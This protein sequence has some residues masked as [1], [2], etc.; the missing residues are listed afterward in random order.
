MTVRKYVYLKEGNVKPPINLMLVRSSVVQ[1]EVLL[2]EDSILT[3]MRWRDHGTFP[4][5]CMAGFLEGNLGQFIAYAD[6]DTLLEM[7]GLWQ[8]CKIEMNPTAWGDKVRCD[9]WA[10]SVQHGPHDESKCG[11]CIWET[12]HV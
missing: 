9:S 8:W 7:K 6:D 1:I 5:D 10:F 2:R 3:L 12:D 4:G 11:T